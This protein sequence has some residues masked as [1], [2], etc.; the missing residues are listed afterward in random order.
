MTNQEHIHHIGKYKLRRPNGKFV[1]VEDDLNEGERN[2]LAFLYFIESIKNQKQHNTEKSIIIIDDPISSMDSAVLFFVTVLI[3]KNI[4]EPLKNDSNGQN[5]IT[6][7]TQN[8]QFYLEITDTNFLKCIPPKEIRYIRL[9]K[10][11]KG[12]ALLPPLLNKKETE[13]INPIKNNYQAL[14]CIIA[15]AQKNK[16]SSDP[17]ICISVRNAMR[18]ILETFLQFKNDFSKG[19]EFN[20]L[21]EDKQ[22][23]INV[24]YRSL[25]TGSHSI[26][27]PLAIDP[28]EPLNI[29][30]NAF[31]LIFEKSGASLHYKKMLEKS[32]FSSS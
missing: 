27:D 6:I 20:D 7:L 11:E 31:E 16:D 15:E 28:N 24:L 19:S 30:L 9:R 2:F 5:I 1:E 25:N 17:V 18:R 23:C 26:E 10:T 3:K 13:E 22:H 8:L 12:T 4:F 29:W 32:G 21:P 14:W